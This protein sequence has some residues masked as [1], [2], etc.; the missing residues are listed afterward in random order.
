VVS[1]AVDEVDM[2]FQVLRNDRAKFGLDEFLSR[3][4]VIHVSTTSGQGARNS[5]FFFLCEGEAFWMILEEG[6]T[7]FRRAC[8]RTCVSRSASWTSVR[9]PDSS[10]T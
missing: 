1:I 5:V 2:P 10:N 6:S 9:R 4:L 8:A 3:P 7:P